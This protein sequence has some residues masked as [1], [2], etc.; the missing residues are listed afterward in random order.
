[1]PGIPG[2]EGLGFGLRTEGL[3]Y[4]G[5]LKS[6]SIFIQKAW[7][8]SDAFFAQNMPQGHVADKR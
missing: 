1:M 8:P 2:G 5:D 3:G 6:F 7:Q 4:S